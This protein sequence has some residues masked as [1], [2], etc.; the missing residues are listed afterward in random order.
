MYYVCRFT[1]TVTIHNV[2]TGQV[3]IVQHRD[4]D[5]IKSTFPVLF[6]K[7]LLSALCVMEVHPKKINGQKPLSGYLFGKFINKWIAYDTA[8]AIYTE[9]A[10][11]GPL[12][13]I[14]PVFAT[15]NNS[16]IIEATEINPNK[17]LSQVTNGN[18]N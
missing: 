6:D 11:I 12:A 14:L 8:S 18:S 7:K 5:L 16:I 2:S 15:S 10:D 17:L 13:S 4:M 1:S 3:T 9:I